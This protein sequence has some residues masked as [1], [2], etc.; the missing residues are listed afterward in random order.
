MGREVFKKAVKR[1][2]EV[3]KEAMDAN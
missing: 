2:P 3:I 1:F